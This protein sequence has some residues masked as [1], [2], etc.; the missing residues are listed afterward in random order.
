MAAGIGEIER[1]REA[2]EG[3]AFFA[4]ELFEDPWLRA[5]ERVAH[6][7]LGLEARTHDVEDPRPQTPRRLELVEDHDHPLARSFRER[8]RQI[9]S[10]FEETL[11][12]GLTGE[13]ERELHVLVLDLHRRVHPRGD[14]LCLLEASFDA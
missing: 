1:D 5:E 11:R 7:A 8:V 2:I 3:V 14:G 10:P 6:A 9:E 4:E 12:V 13:L